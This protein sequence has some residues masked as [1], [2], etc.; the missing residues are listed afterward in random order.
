MFDELPDE[1]SRFKKWLPGFKLTHS[2]FL[3]GQVHVVFRP[4][5]TA[6]ASAISELKEHSTRLRKVWWNSV[7]IP[8]LRSLPPNTR[9]RRYNIV[10]TVQETD[11]LPRYARLYEE[12]IA[13]IDQALQASVVDDFEWFF[14][15]F[16]FGQRKLLEE[17]ESL[18][19]EAFGL[20]T[21]FD[22]SNIV[23]IS[24]HLAVNLTCT[25]ELYSL[26]WHRKR[27]YSWIQGVLLRDNFRN[28]NTGGDIRGVEL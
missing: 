1:L 7:L 23:K 22:L 9:T 4:K 10:R 19:P 18:G 21:L 3:Y 24:L 12:D 15:C 5:S 27:T 11:I 8:A 17:D 14:I 13:D 6:D 26:F 2:L 20:G 28:G 25:D 16:G